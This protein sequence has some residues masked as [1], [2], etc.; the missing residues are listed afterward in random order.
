MR[1]AVRRLSFQKLSNSWAVRSMLAG[2]CAAASDYGLLFLGVEVFGLPKVP[3][4]EAGVTLGGVVGFLLNKYF[5]FRDPSQQV[6][7]Q[8][9][10]FAAILLPEL[11]LHSALTSF[12]IH[13]MKI[14][15]VP[16]KLFAD[17]LIFTCIHLFLLRHVVFAK[18][19]GPVQPTLAVQASPAE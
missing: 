19:A 18:P 17:F 2:A 12:L 4:I 3:C 8:A 13:Q 11:M 16:A 1:V 10:K 5:A 7:R 9:A 6:W 15:Y 14:P